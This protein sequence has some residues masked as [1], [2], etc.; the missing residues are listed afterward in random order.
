MKHE[1]S[2]SSGT[3]ENVNVN[4]SECKIQVMWDGIPFFINTF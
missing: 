3:P 1:G 4:T 2:F